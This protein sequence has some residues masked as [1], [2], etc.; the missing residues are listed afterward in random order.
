MKRGAYLFSLVS[1][2]ALCSYTNTHITAQI[3]PDGTLP[4]NSVVTPD[5]NTSVITGGTAA[6]GNLF[7]SFSSFS[8]PAGNQAYFNNALTVENIFGRVTGKNLSNLNGLIR[9]N[10]TA[11]L[12][13]INPNG[14]IFGPNASLNIGGS[15]F[16]STADQINF[17]DGS[18]FS[19]KEPQSSPLLT[20]NVPVGL[21][22][23]NSS[24][25][26]IVN[27]SVA[28]VGE[29]VVGLQVN[30]GE[31]LALLGGNV[32]LDGG[33]LTAP[34]GQIELGSVGEQSLIRLIPTETGIA[35]GYEDVQAF[36]DIQLLRQSVVNTSGAG[37][38]AIQVRGRQINLTD[39]SAIISN[40]LGLNNGGGIVIEAERFL[41][42]NGAFVSSLTA[43]AGSSGDLTVRASES[44]HLTGSGNFIETLL[45]ILN[46]TFDSNNIRDGIFTA[47]FGAGNSGNLTIK[48]SRFTAENGALVLS[49]TFNQGE[50]GALSVNATESVN[51]VNAGLLTG[52]GGPKA[53]GDLTITTTR[54][55]LLEG[56]VLA[57]SSLG[58]GRGGNITVNA[59][60]SVEVISPGE[61]IFIPI[62]GFL[63]PIALGLSAI[64]SESFSS[65]DA[66]NLII[67]TKRLGV[68]NNGLI[69]T[70]TTG[71]GLAG[72]LTI[73]ALDKVEVMGNFSVIAT[74]NFG[75]VT[76]SFNSAGDLRIETKQLIVRNGGQIQTATFGR[77]GGGNLYIKASESIELSGT[78]VDKSRV[79]GL[80]SS[81]QEF[82][83][84]NVGNAGNIK[85]ETGR[86][87]VRDGARISVSGERTGNAGNLEIIA[88]SIYLDNGSIR[89][90]TGAGDFGNILIQSNDIQL[91][92]GSNI[93]TDAGNSDGGNIRI[94]TGTLAALENSDITA[95]AQQGRGG[96]VFIDAQGIFGTAYRL[97][98]NL[99]TSDITATSELGV[100]FNGIVEIDLLEVNLNAGLIDLPANF[101]NAE[102]LIVL[103]CE[104]DGNASRFINTGTGGLP[105]EPSEALASNAFWDD[106]RPLKPLET[107]LVAEITPPR[108]AAPDTLV[109]A[110]G[111]VKD[112]NG[113]IVLTADVPVATPHTPWQTSA[114]CDGKGTRK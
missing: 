45:S 114:G 63:R 98:Q 14:I 111:W 59:A 50:G 24:N 92:R 60:E 62:N 94:T 13:L 76:N 35:L 52:T 29:Q 56:G 64:S 58:E 2:I 4:V 10:G 41:V 110:Q 106:L 8:L 75:A 89:A 32:T 15:F 51:I 83:V 33:H 20:I 90:R 97:R 80:L 9:A 85:I 74:S 23:G 109:E 3:V 1:S 18:F 95:D 54:L 68:R 102:R 37:G 93:A 73:N 5:G 57:T 105:P 65:A 12:F 11:N 48:T 16:A 99:A 67:N 19:A 7:H 79:S 36:K 38:G 55:N 40:T 61:P 72:K 88:N 53:S 104:S 108:T 47:S 42:Q 112:G 26:S 86:L 43:G 21:Q 96:Q 34:Q 39:G 82:G 22:F 107:A 70:N 78:S 77:G 100:Q 27:Q 113:N 103:G 91:R 66:G 49:S 84:E 6:G 44:V 101:V 17:K 25:G 81:S 71:E 28:K 31:T 69:K 46:R 30:A 87:V